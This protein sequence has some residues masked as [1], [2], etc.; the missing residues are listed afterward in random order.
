MVFSCYTFRLTDAS[1]SMA[2]HACLGGTLASFHVQFLK[3]RH[4]RIS[5]VSKRVDFAVTDLKRITT[6]HFDVYFYL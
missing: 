3:E 6:S 1:V 2:L 5:V 4:Y